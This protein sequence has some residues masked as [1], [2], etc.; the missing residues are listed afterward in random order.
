MDTA[1][2]TS[3]P[4]RSLR[5]LAP[6]PAAGLRARARIYATWVSRGLMHPDC[7]QRILAEDASSLRADCGAV[8]AEFPALATP[9]RHGGH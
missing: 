7:A 1:P 2:S 9:A 4:P 8:L 5:P 3:V 6:L